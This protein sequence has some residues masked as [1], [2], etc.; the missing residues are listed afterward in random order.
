MPFGNLELDG[1][2]GLQTD[3]LEGH[4]TVVCLQ[5][6]TISRC[7]TLAD[8]SPVDLRAAAGS[9]IVLA[10]QAAGNGTGGQQVG[11]SQEA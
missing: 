7:P 2:I 4:I 1:G 11:C 9:T 3:W 6:T 10:T 8:W 5:G